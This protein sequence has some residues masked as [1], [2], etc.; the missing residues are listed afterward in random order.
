MKRA[1]V[2]AILISCCAWA[3]SPVFEI[4]E[5]RVSKTAPADS[6]AVLEDTR[7]EFRGASMLEMIAAAYHVP[8]ERVLGGPSWLDAD[9]F[10]VTA[11]APRDTPEEAVRVMLQ[12]LLAERFKL[13]VRK[14]QR[15]VPTFVLTVSK[16]GLKLKESSG[17]RPSDCQRDG[18]HQ[19]NLGLNC[20]HTTTAQIVEFLPQAAGAYLPHPVIDETGLKGAYDFSLEWTGRGL[21]RG[22]GDDATKI[23]LFDAVD[24]QLGL[25]LDPKIGRC[26]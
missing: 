25:K 9:R 6:Y 22:G 21:L 11:R 5:A 23:S 8:N 10:D 18:S 4:A 2:V 7:V 1:I 3:Q 20:V 14:D 19:P 26:R 15:P 17:D 24:K 12:G 16:R 13:E